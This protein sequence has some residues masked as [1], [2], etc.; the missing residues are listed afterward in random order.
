MLTEEKIIC[1]YPGLR[2]FREDESIFLR[3]RDA[4]VEQ[5]T[6]QLEQK[7]FLMLT[8]ASG[9]GK[10]SL[11]YAGLIPN[12]RA[13]FFKAKF[14]NWQVVD[15]RPERAPLQNLEDALAARFSGDVRERFRRELKFGFSSLIDIYTDSPHFVD[16]S[17]P[18][19]TELTEADQRKAMRK[20]SNLLILVDQFE[21][22]FTNSENYF[23]GRSSADAQLVVSMLLETCRIATE[24]DLPVYVV[25]TMRSDYI[26]Q[27]ASFRGLPEAI[28]YSQ[29]F[30]PRLKRKEI[31]QVI[32]EPALLNGNKISKRLIE[33]LLN[34]L[35]EGIDQLPVLQHALNQIWHEASEGAEEMDLIHFA[36]VGGVDISYLPVSD[37]GSFEAW[38]SELPE[39]RQPFYEHPSLDNVLDRHANDLYHSAHAYFLQRHPGHSLTSDQTR[40]I[41]DTAFRSLTKIDASRSVRN[42]MTLQE[43]VRIVNRPEL[44]LN[45]VSGVLE[46][47]RLPG[48]TFLKPFYESEEVQ[49]DAQ[50]EWIMDITHESLIRNWGKLV[51]W[52]HAEEQ[53][54]QTWLDFTKQLNR[55]IDNGK[56]TGYLLPIGPL[57]FFETWFE[58]KQPN[59]HWLMKYDERDISY[60]QKLKE[61]STTLTEARRFIRASIGKLFFSRF[62]MKHGAQRVA[63]WACMA[64]LLF[65]CEYFRQDYVSKTN[66]SVVRE[67]EY[68][69][70][71]LLSSARVTAS[72]KARFII[73]YEGLHPG[74]MEAML[75]RCGGDSVQLLV[76]KSVAKTILPNGHQ[77]QKNV[78]NKGL[79]ASYLLN[80]VLGS[81]VYR[82]MALRKTMA[83]SSSL[84]MNIRLCNTGLLLQSCIT[85]LET[86]TDTL[87]QCLD[88]LSEVIWNDVFWNPAT[89]RRSQDP[90]LM[91]A[92][93]ELLMI[94]G[95]SKD[96][97]GQLLQ[98]IS[99]LH[100]PVNAEYFYRCF[101][102]GKIL[103]DV[104][105]KWGPQI[106]G[107]GGYH[108]LAQIYSY[109]NDV[110]NCSRTL[111]S[112]VM[113]D[114]EFI[115][116]D[117]YLGH[118]ML[119]IGAFAWL[120]H[121]STNTPSVITNHLKFWN[122]KT[123]ADKTASSR[124]FKLN[125]L[126]VSRSYADRFNIYLLKA[127]HCASTLHILF[128][129]LAEN[130]ARQILDSV[131]EEIRGEEK[132]SE[133]RHYEQALLCKWRIE[134]AIGNR[135][136]TLADSCLQ[137]FYL[138]AQSCSPD[139]LSQDI[140]VPEE[141]NLRIS[142]AS[143]LYHPTFAS[144]GW[145]FIGSINQYPN[146]L[147]NY[148]FSSI[149]RSQLFKN[150][151]WSEKDLA[152]IIKWLYAGELPGR[153]FKIDNS[154]D[155]YDVGNLWLLADFLSNRISNDI[156]N[157]EVLVCKSF[158]DC[159]LPD[160]LG[161]SNR[162][163]FLFKSEED[164]LFKVLLSDSEEDILS[165][166][167][168][169]AF[170][171]LTRV[172]MSRPIDDVMELI[173]LNTNTI[174]KRNLLLELSERAFQ[175]GGSEQAIAL[176]SKYSD[177]FDSTTRPCGL[178]FY[179]AA[180]VGGDAVL[181]WA[182]IVFKD[183]KE[184]GKLQFNDCLAI[185][186]ASEGNYQLALA[187]Q[188]PGF[189]S[190]AELG[191]LNCI[192]SE[193]VRHLSPLSIYCN[194][195]IKWEVE[196][197][198]LEK[199]ATEDGV[200]SAIFEN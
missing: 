18:E 144:D 164:S 155:Y 4:H 15:F 44:G 3:G 142:R 121:D 92:A 137:E 61:A 78:V 9:D 160:S 32:E 79:Q 154:D 82:Q 193:E 69:G 87:Q 48:N 59:A 97:L 8:G 38:R 165:F 114:P 88:S 106:K 16:K 26:G 112:L 128:R 133:A 189:S 134:W 186:Y 66:E 11:V 56:T 27:C 20:G 107:S 168:C 47:F 127:N 71:E 40:E 1:P 192:L 49:G 6:R 108:F 132:N 91:L 172:M 152:E 10:S 120:G 115:K 198:L 75:Q 60:E 122:L 123:S 176:F 12:A 145:G 175:L 173:D 41:I 146:A 29:F 62:V 95:F 174:Y 180:R 24:R 148:F 169:L 83:D 63:L 80:R 182:D 139:Y 150:Y 129:K 86:N 196:F 55:W 162:P 74:T 46:I 116:R 183:S 51:E 100:D 163:H 45:E 199:S 22:F 35:G 58:Q 177:E 94:N 170:H 23:E 109:R 65:F 102:K 14:N 140:E 185:G 119:Y 161:I 76:M 99:P 159:L 113:L 53:D 13:G 118:N 117:T 68:R 28:G 57:N 158:M 103:P 33:M 72:E 190:G 67:A 195:K 167:R 64:I 143:N 171:Y 52:S 81:F 191:L 30:V 17:K 43:I 90:G 54:H 25:C 5:I 135:D 7:K 105:N 126:D 39:W 194:N 89:E 101:P 77:F 179:L 2:P 187:R 85:Q 84:S 111:D 178:F 96:L 110:Q 200:V 31:Y 104:Q 166:K 157:Q 188:L 93:S 147:G 42:R 124:A 130:R 156:K 184:S 138:H 181:N 197:M 98:K 151:K 37:R 125:F 153:Y 136:T 141:N 50:G 70:I 149:V 36:R 21:E 19:F 34:Q 73:N 131:E